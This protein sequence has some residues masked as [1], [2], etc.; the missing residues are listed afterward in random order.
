LKSRPSLLRPPYLLTG[1]TNDVTGWTDYV[2]MASRTKSGGSSDSSD[3]KKRFLQAEEVFHNLTLSSRH[4]LASVNYHEFKMTLTQRYWVR[5]WVPGTAAISLSRRD[6]SEFR[7]ET[8][9]E[10]KSTNQNFQAW[11]NL[12]LVWCSLFFNTRSQ[13]VARIADRT[14]SHVV[15]EDI[16]SN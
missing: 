8:G 15:F 7:G 16:Y 4:L 3:V 14:A 11:V 9:V 5:R 12:F 13:A 10:K 2:N 6:P 1:R